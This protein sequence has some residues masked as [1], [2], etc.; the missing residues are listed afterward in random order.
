MTTEAAGSTPRATICQLCHRSVWKATNPGPAGAWYHHHNGSV[1]C[2]P[3]S[4]T[5]RKAIPLEIKPS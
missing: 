3:G 5:G 4:G 1:F 2:S